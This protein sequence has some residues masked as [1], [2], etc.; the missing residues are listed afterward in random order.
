MWKSNGTWV[1]YAKYAATYN[2][3]N[4]QTYEAHS[5]WD[6]TANSWYYDQR[7][8]FHYNGNNV[9]TDYSET[10]WGINT[11]ALSDSTID[12]NTISNNNIVRTLLHHWDGSMY[13]FDTTA[14]ELFTYDAHH[15]RI[16]WV[17]QTENIFKTG[18]QNNDSAAFTYD[19]NNNQIGNY[20]YT[21]MNGPRY[22]DGRYIY[23]YDATNNILSEARHFRNGGA[24]FG[25]STYYYYG[26]V[27]GIQQVTKDEDLLSIYPNPTN[28]NFIIETNSDQNQVLKIVDVTGKIVWQQKTQ[29]REV[30]NADNL[31]SGLYTVVLVN[32]K[33]TVTRKLMIIK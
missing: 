2:A 8:F 17:D 29:G 28:N 32:N 16:S 3:A 1:N 19:S 18:W 30:I 6:T 5:V 31:D 11:H 10:F 24:W 25:D 21:W 13:G 22:Y 26:A 9:E 4:K 15:N 12:T 33:A 23:T 27:S 7:Y 20:G 14:Q